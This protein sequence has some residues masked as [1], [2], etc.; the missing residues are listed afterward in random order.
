MGDITD[1]LIIIQM[2]SFLAGQRALISK[3]TNDDREPTDWVKG[4]GEAVENSFQYL[5]AL[6]GMANKVNGGPWANT[7]KEAKQ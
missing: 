7:Y 4:Y 1:T 3:A 5:D 2:K 6:M